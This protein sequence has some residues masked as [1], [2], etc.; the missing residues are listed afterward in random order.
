MARTHLS[1]T[2]DRVFQLRDGRTLGYAEYGMPS[3][4]ALFYF[5]ASRLEARFLAEQ[6]AHTGI[7]LIGVDRPGMG[8][9]D[10]KVD[11]SLLDWPDDVV[12]LAD[13]LQIARFAVVGVSGGGPYV[14][15]CAY[16]IPER[17]IACGIV[18]GVG[19]ARVRPY[20]RMPWL[21]IPLMWI[22]GRFFQTDAQA[23]KSLRRFTRGWPESDRRCLLL[24]DISDLFAASMVEA[25]RQ[26]TRGLTYDTI[27]G[28][29]RPWGF[30]LADIAFPG[31]YL[32][33]GEQ[34]PDA[35][36][37]MGKAV[38][39]QTPDCKATFYPEE[40][41][42]STLI[43]HSEEIVTALMANATKRPAEE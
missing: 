36:L 23:S 5:G 3:G 27:L 13:H 10:F 16:R 28:E 33:H 25:F 9:S 35:P 41:H 34:D 1:K 32:W 40:G 22:M 6:A 8:V 7:R 39:D 18:S 38:A 24:P 37:A 14:L 15:A 2:N 26:G 4:G 11:R 30:K 31:I 21:L 43:N 20:Q 17:L 12:E 29:T 19:P 42:L